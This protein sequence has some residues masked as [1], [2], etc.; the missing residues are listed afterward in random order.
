MMFLKNI[1]NLILILNL[2]PKYVINYIKAQIMKP[3]T[4]KM[5]PS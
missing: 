2:T 5:W 3:H 4:K 1:E